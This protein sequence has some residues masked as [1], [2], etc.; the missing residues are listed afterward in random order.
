MSN[1][2]N[3][4]TRFYEYTIRLNQ[5]TARWEVFW[6]DRKERGDFARSSDAQQ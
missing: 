1:D 4:Q 3:Q 5:G 2:Q 6:Q